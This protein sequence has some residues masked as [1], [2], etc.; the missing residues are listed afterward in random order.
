MSSSPSSTILLSTYQSTTR[1][2]CE[3]GNLTIA[4][5][6][7]DPLSQACL[8]ARVQCSK[9]S[10]CCVHASAYICNCHTYFDRWPISLSSD[11][12][13]SHF[14]FDHYIVPSAVTVWPSLTIPGDRCVDQG[15]VQL[16]YSRI[17]ELVFRKRSREII[18]DQDVAFLDKR[19][20]D[21]NSIWIVERKPQAL[22]VSIDL[23]WRQIGRD[24]IVMDSRS[25]LKD[26][27]R[28]RQGTA[29]QH[30]QYRVHLE[31]PMIVC[32]RLAWGVQS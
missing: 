20:E 30:R 25:S 18:L 24:G 23:I 11:V 26:S 7:V 9:D 16:R 8:F 5:A 22:L 21:G 14:C 13:E 28:S 32:R 6:R 3:A 31:G 2:V 29:A 15:W 4:Q 10:D 1:N 27:M 19:M 17:I 12:H